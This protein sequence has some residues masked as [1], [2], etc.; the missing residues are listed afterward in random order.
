MK[1]DCGNVVCA[2][3][4]SHTKASKQTDDLIAFTFMTNDFTATLPPINVNKIH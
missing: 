4:H 2:P 1:M 3:D